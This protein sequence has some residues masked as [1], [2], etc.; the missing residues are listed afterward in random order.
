VTTD[1]KAIVSEWERGDRP[2]AITRRHRLRREA[3][4]NIVA[5]AGFHQPPPRTGINLAL[6]RAKA[7]LARQVALGRQEIQEALARGHRR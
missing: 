4:R 6:E 7:E 2:Y 5:Q 1:E 3:L